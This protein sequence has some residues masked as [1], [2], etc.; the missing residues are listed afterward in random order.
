MFLSPGVTPWETTLPGVKNGANN[1]GIR[2]FEYDDATLVVQVRHNALR[3]GVKRVAVALRLEARRGAAVESRRRG[4][5]DWRS[6][7]IC[8]SFSAN[9][10]IRLLEQSRQTSRLFT[11]APR[12]Q[13][14]ASPRQ[15]SHRQSE[16]GEF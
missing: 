16:S 15:R 6:L 5:T 12:N 4:A 13:D 7:T 9:R 14:S 3:R 1:P 8:S 2:I 11:C 10:H